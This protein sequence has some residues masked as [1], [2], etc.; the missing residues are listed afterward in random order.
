MVGLEK[1]GDAR[2]GDVA[3][4]YLPHLLVSPRTLPVRR[5]FR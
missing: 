4:S 3:S 5:R 2:G 1:E